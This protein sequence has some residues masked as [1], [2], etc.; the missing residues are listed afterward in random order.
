MTRQGQARHVLL[1]CCRYLGDSLLLRPVIRALHQSDSTIRITAAVAPGTGVALADCEGLEKVIEWSRSPL[2]I[3]GG[4]ARIAALRVDEAFD[5]TGSDRT[6]LITLASM[7]KRRVAYERP[8]WPRFS[9]RRLAYN[10]RPRHPKPKPHILQQRLNLLRL[11]GYS[12]SDRDPG[13]GLSVSTLAGDRIAAMFSGPSNRRLVVHPTSRD[14]LKALPVNFVRDTIR[15]VNRAGWQV[16][17]TAGPAPREREFLR[18][19]SDGFQPEEAVV[20]PTL[21]WEEMTA[22]LMNSAAFLGCDTAPAHLAAAIGIRRM[23]VFGPSN[24]AHWAWEEESCQNLFLDCPCREKGDV[25][26][27]AGQPGRCMSGLKG[28]TVAGWLG[29]TPE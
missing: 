12:L 22:L 5:F 9:L 6:A 7:A 17:L 20:A 14:F 28:E 8:N 4:I 2:S 16:V 10:F 18:A 29:P 11:S 3:A 26:C 21:S 23:V 1:I 13:F 19:C 15:L 24:P 25:Q 27:P